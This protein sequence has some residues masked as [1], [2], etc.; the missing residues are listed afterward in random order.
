MVKTIDTMVDKITDEYIFMLR[1]F[2]AKVKNLSHH[3]I[4]EVVLTLD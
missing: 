1:I 2:F 4:N 3:V